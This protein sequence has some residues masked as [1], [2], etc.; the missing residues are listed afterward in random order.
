MRKFSSLLCYTEKVQVFSFWGDED[1][2]GSDETLSGAG[3]DGDF[4][5]AIDR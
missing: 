2:G 5:D 1:D 4:D 3:G